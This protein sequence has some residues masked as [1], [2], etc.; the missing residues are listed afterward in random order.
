MEPKPL[1]HII[2]SNRSRDRRTRTST[3]LKRMKKPRGV[4]PSG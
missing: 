3:A 4:E 1:Q 2:Y